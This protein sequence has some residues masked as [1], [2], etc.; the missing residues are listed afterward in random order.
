MK[1][2]INYWLNCGTLLGAIRH[3]GYI[4]WDDDID[5][6][7]LRE[8]Y[9]R[10]MELFNASNDKYRF[11]AFELDH[12]YLYA[13]G[14][15]I[16]TDTVLYE[17]DETG[18]KLAINID[19]FVHDN[20]PDDDK[21][22]K[23][24]YWK[25]DLLR[26]LHLF[27]N[28]LLGT[29]GKPLRKII[30]AIAKVILSVFPKHFFVAQ[31]IKISKKYSNVATERIGDFTC[32]TKIASKKSTVSSFIKAEFE[33]KMYNIPSGYDEWLRNMY[34]DYMQLPPV[35]KRVSHHVYMA[36]VND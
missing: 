9:D 3:K 10:F 7:M 5:L 19:I 14:K 25:R 15:V 2:G 31:I 12:N 33:G 16:D 6:G 36:Y 32:D 28:G 21:R 4:P 29:N 35:E 30:V 8:D 20:A 11:C 13:S 26:I 23:N 17:P 18:N 1:N 24:M 34:G 22:L 27:R